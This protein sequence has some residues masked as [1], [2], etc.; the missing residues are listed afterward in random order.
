MHLTCPQVCLKPVTVSKLTLAK[1]LSK[2]RFV[3]ELCNRCTCGAKLAQTAFCTVVSRRRQDAHLNPGAR[4]SREHLE[5]C[6]T[7]LSQTS[8]GVVWVV[9]PLQRSAV[10]MISKP[11][12]QSRHGVAPSVSCYVRR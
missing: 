7:R 4:C 1:P 12:R 3:L 11:G 8:F 2:S 10:C 9:L 5:M 6:N